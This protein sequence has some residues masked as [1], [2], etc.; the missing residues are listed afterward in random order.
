MK[1]IKLWMTAVL[2]VSILC[3]SCSNTKYNTTYTT[4]SNVSPSNTGASIVQ[5]KEPELKI[6]QQIKTDMD[7]SGILNEINLIYDK[8]RLL[9]KADHSISDLGPVDIDYIAGPPM[10]KVIR[11]NDQKKYI[12]V[13]DYSLSCGVVGKEYK[14]YL[15]KYNNDKGIELL[16]DGNLAEYEYKY[17][18]NIIHFTFSDFKKEVEGDII[19]VVKNIES[20]YERI[21]PMSIN[22]FLNGSIIMSLSDVGVNDYNGDGSEELITK[23][24]VYNEQLSMYLSSIY[25]VWEIENDK[26]YIN[27]IF[28][29]DLHSFEARVLSEIIEKGYLQYEKL[30]LL[31]NEDDD[32]KD[33]TK[34][35][36]QLVQKG[37]VKIQ[38]SRITIN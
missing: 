18:D 20:Q 5:E 14:L 37:I 24:D 26:V 13:Y 9:L 21:E 1:R 33:Y 27:N 38:D 6:I 25:A 11:G 2:L 34:Q 29:I 12:A 8:G 30:Q 7:N 17:S 4:K 31:V 23:H 3:S 36:D 28:I 32:E 19:N 22:K 16:W 15:F 35:M 10:L